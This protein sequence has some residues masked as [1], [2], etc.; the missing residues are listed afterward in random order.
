MK[1]KNRKK[2]RLRRTHRVVVVWR[3][4]NIIIVRAAR[5]DRSS[6]KRQKRARDQ[7]QSTFPDIDSF[8]RVALR[9]FETARLKYL[10][11]H[12][13]PSRRRRRC[14][15]NESNRLRAHIIL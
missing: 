5:R 1:K 7:S 15:E 4:N 13:V 3:R 6:D 11:L 9:K 8:T 2:K 10:K 12:F 14:R